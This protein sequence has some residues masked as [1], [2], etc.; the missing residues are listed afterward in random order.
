MCLGISSEGENAGAHDSEG[1]WFESNRQGQIT[2]IGLIG[3][4]PGLGPG[5]SQFESAVRDQ[6]LE[7]FQQSKILRLRASRKATI[8]FH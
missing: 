1:S 8:L 7:S 6:N 2:R 5:R 3:K 4:S